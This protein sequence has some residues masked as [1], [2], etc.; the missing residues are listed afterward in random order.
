MYAPEPLALVMPVQS[1]FTKDH[2]LNLAPRNASSDKSLNKTEPS[3]ISSAPSRSQ[4][5][6]AEP[7][8]PLTVDEPMTRE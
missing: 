4:L 3:T 2:R 7:L 8:P 6:T 5:P 1:K